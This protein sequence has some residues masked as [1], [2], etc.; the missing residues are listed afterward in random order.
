LPRPP[1]PSYHVAHGKLKKKTTSEDFGV[2][3]SNNDIKKMSES[4]LSKHLMK[5][6]RYSSKVFNILLND[7]SDLVPYTLN[8][9]ELEDI[10]SSLYFLGYN[11]DLRQRGGG[12]R[13]KN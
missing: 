11:V 9:V 12:R 1:P 4:K 2:K 3:I 5:D 6:I 7:T 10:I 13:R 8:T